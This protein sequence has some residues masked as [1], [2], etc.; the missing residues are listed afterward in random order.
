VAI[1]DVTDHEAGTEPFFAPGKR[2]DAPPSLR[3]ATVA[4]LT[5]R[6]SS[7]S[8]ILMASN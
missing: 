8:T 5:A 3:R 1:V 6:G 7:S 2:W 4:S